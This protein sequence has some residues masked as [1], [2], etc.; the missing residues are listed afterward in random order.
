[1]F[2]T[3]WFGFYLIYGSSFLPL[4]NVTV[5]CSDFNPSQVKWNHALWLVLCNQ[6][7]LVQTKPV[8]C[9]LGPIYKLCHQKCS[10]FTVILSFHWYLHWCKFIFQM[11]SVSQKGENQTVFSLISV[12]FWNAQVWVWLAIFQA[13]NRHGLT[14]KW[15]SC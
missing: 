15:D 6:C 11:S 12:D 1:M 5:S 4:K 7:Q 9:D 10:H 8:L 13:V 2:N 14:S 3:W